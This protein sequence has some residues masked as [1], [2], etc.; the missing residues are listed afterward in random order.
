MS[1]RYLRSRRTLRGPTAWIRGIGL[2][3]GVDVAVRVLPASTGSGIVFRNA[4]GQTIPADV[5]H[6]VYTER[7]TVLG[8]EDFQIQTVEHMLAALYGCVVDDAIIEVDGPELPA[9]DGSAFPFIE[10]IEHV[11]CKE[12]DLS[13]VEPLIIDTEFI[14]SNDSGGCITVAPS[15]ELDVSVELQ[16]DSH[17]YLGTIGARMSDLGQFKLEIASSRTFGFRTELAWLQSKGLGLGASHDNAIV[18]GDDRYESALRHNNELA[19]HK[20]LD[21]IGD[22]SLIGRP[23]CAK[24]VALRPSHSLNNRLAIRFAETSSRS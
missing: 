17:S 23:I 13:A 14:V 10:I 18:L 6:V 5:A 8:S 2:H 9:V 22:I 16:Y 12:Q 24:I 20:I 19:R 7:C 15:D 3:S 4:Q 11:G 1:S 21:I